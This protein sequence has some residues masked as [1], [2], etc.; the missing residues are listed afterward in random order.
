MI[1]DKLSNAFFRFLATTPRSRVI[2]GGG[3]GATKP[4]PPPLNGGK[5]RGP[6]G[7]E[8]TWAVAAVGLS[9]CSNPPEISNE[10]GKTSVARA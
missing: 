2:S 8:L 10:S 5:S 9:A 1:S 4:S 3:V 7:R 6:S